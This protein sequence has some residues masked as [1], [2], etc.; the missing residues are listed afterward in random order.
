MW[1]DVQCMPSKSHIAFALSLSYQ[2]TYNI[3]LEGRGDARVRINLIQKPTPILLVKNTRKP[4][5]LIFKGLDILN[6]DAE[7]IAWFGAFN[8]KGS[9]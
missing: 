6:L 2:S 4:P 3:Y 5:R 1:R 8:L 9:R 7:Y